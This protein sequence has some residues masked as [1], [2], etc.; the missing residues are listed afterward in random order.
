[1]INETQNSCTSLVCQLQFGH[2]FYRFV[3]MRNFELDM[4]GLY[5]LPNSL[6]CKKGK[7]NVLTL[8]IKIEKEGIQTSLIKSMLLS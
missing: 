7:W 4:G 5:T 8:Q 1:M 3:R 2:M 6:M